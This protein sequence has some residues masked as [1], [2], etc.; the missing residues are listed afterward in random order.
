MDLDLYH[1]RTDY[2]AQ[3]RIVT[4]TVRPNILL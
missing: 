1:I 4:L 2:A 3:F